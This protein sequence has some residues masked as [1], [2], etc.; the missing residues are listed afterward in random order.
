MDQHTFLFQAVVYLAA[1]VIF[2]PLAMRIGLG[3]V[4]GFLIAGM[5]IGSELDTDDYASDIQAKCQRNGLL[6]TAEGSTLLLLPS[7]NIDQAIA[8]QGLDILERCI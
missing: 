4:L 2:V 6:I 5:A 8:K 7:L 3:S 1:A